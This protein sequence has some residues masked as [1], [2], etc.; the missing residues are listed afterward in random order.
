MGITMPML[1]LIATLSA[2]QRGDSD[3]IC[4]FVARTHFLT[5]ALAAQDID[6]GVDDRQ[7]SDF[8]ALPIY[9][10]PSVCR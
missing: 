4:R 3:A 9:S 7:C 1:E 8:H 2:M 6:S 5:Q 10:M